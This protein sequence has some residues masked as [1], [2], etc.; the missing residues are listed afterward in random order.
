MPMICLASVPLCFRE[1]KAREVFTLDV[2]L[3]AVAGE[4]LGSF[5]RNGRN[6]IDRAETSQGSQQKGGAED[7]GRWWFNRPGFDERTVEIGDSNG[8]GSPLGIR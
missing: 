6:G 4:K 7:H 1:S 8:D 5:D 3:I 2:E